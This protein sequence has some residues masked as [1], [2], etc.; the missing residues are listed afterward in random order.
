LD[1]LFYG[2]VG[3][4]AFKIGQAGI[5]VGKN[6]DFL[7]QAVSLPIKSEKSYFGIVGSRSHLTKETTNYINKIRKE[8]QDV[9]II[10]KGS[11]LKICMIAEG[12]A[13]VYPRF[14]PIS[15]WDT[16]AGHAIVSASGGKVVQATNTYYE[17]KYNK[18][19]ILNPWFIAQR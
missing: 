3:C 7:D 9:K 14:A 5:I 2:E 8:H 13:D 19:N 4:G 10:S 18:E 12:I 16:A 6:K 17:I 11:S 1:E 15:E